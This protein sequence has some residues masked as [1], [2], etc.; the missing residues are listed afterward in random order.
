MCLDLC[1]CGLYICGVN[2]SGFKDLLLFVDVGF[3]IVE[4]MDNG[5]CYVIK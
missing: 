1:E 4:I 5:F 3:F 2:F